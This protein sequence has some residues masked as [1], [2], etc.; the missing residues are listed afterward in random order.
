MWTF[1]VNIE[2]DIRVMRVYAM[3]R[4]DYFTTMK[5]RNIA[6]EKMVSSLERVCV[7]VNF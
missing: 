7:P 1:V 3:C 4:N 5:V 6:T 2:N